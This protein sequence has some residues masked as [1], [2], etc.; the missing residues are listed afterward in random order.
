M[1]HDIMEFVEPLPASYIKTAII[2]MAEAGLRISEV[3][4]LTIDC[5]EPVTD[6]E[7]KTV[8]KYLKRLGKNAPVEL[9][10]SKSYWLNYHITKNK[11]GNITKGTPILVGES[12][13]NAINELIELTVD[14][15][16]EAK[17]NM[18]FLNKHNKKIT[19][20]STSA[21]RQDRDKLIKKGMPYF[22]FHQFR[23]T[24]ATIL[25]RLGVPLGMIEKYLNHM[26]SDVTNG[27]INSRR[28]ENTT[29]FNKILNESIGGN[30]N[31]KAFLEYQR[32]LLSMFETSE[33]NGLSYN[34]QHKML[35]RLMQKHNIKLGSADHGTCVLPMDRECPNGYEGVNPCHTEDCE[36]F[37]PDSDEESENFF[38]LSLAKTENKEIELKKFAQEHGSVHVNFEQI[39]KAKKSLNNILT[40]IRSN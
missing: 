38:I 23:A 22:R 35:E 4:T 10:Y 30:A 31:N 14:L 17:N 3:R 39:N 28:K 25:N 37:M 9:D 21:L 18:L 34:S 7:I 6:P 12:V 27:Y 26:Y 2:V 11:G 19:V 16:K 13:K 5:L 29:I 24:F 36:C 15:R 1:L 40:Q 33:F 8:A 32:E 20:R